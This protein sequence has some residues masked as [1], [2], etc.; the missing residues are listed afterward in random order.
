MTRSRKTIQPSTCRTCNGEGQVEDFLIVG[1]G[2]NTA[3]IRT[4]AFCLD[5]CGA[6]TTS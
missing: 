2:K 6:S 5:C 3:C 1:R 4:W